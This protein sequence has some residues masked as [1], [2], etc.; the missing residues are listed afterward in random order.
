[1]IN[2]NIKKITLQPRNEIWWDKNFGP[3]WDSL[4]EQEKIKSY[5]YLWKI[6][7]YWPQKIF[8]NS[9]EKLSQLRADLSKLSQD[10]IFST[11]IHNLSLELISFSEG[12]NEIV[13]AAD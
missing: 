11:N 12:A 3:I 6:E 10:V 4:Y 9:P 1:M 5:Q 7:P 13:F 8:F 2:I